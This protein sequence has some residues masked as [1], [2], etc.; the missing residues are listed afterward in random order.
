M[1]SSGWIDRQFARVHPAVCQII[2][3]L[4]SISSGEVEFEGMKEMPISFYLEV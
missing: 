3:V 1:F 2:I 4:E